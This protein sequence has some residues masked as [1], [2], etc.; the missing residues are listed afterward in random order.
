MANTRRTPA[1]STDEIHARVH[2]TRIERL[3]KLIDLDFDGVISN[4]IKADSTKEKRSRSS[5]ISQIQSGH[6]PFTEM[7]ARRIEV[8]CTKPAGW[9]D[10]IADGELTKK[11]NASNRRV[12]KLRELIDGRHLGDVDAFIAG[13]ALASRRQQLVIDLLDG[14]RFL[15]KKSAE[16][17]EKECRLGFGYLDEA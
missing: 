16:V 13:H 9:L 3:R 2:T 11:E 1:E 7:A 6:R 8:D 10:G 4:M 5:Y 12:A 15:S 14:R 17:L